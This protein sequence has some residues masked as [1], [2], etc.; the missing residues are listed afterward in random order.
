[1]EIANNGSGTH[2]LQS[3]IEII[4]MEEEEILLQKCVENNILK[5]SQNSNG[6]HIIQKI[7]SCFEEKNRNYLNDFILNNLSKMC[8]NANGICVVSY[9]YLKLD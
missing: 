1:M 8:M 2:S 9:K 5:L 4:N 6:T 7:I 3:I